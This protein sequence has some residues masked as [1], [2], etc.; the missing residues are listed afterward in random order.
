[1]IRVL[2]VLGNLNRGGAETMIMNL[3][4]NIDR[5]KVQFDFIIHTKE[6]CDYT[7]EVKALGGKIFS[8]PKYTGKN[9]RQYKKHWH[10]FFKM[11]QEYKI[12][13]GHVRS[14]ASIYLNIA[15]RYG[16][17]TIVHSHSTSSGKGLSALVKNL[18]QYRIRNIS[19]YLFACSESAGIWLFG[20]KS[21]KRD[22]FYI[23]KNAVD[24]KKYIYNERIRLEKRKE[25]LLDGRFVVGH[26]GRFHE[27]KNHN[28]LVDI[29]KS[30]YDQNKKAVLM[31]VGDGQLRQS[32]EKKV[33][34]LGLG[35]SVIFTGVRSNIPELLQV[36]DV[37]VFPSIYEGLPVTLIEAQA[38]GLK[39][40][41]SDNITSEVN[42]T[43]LVKN[44]SLKDT[45][46]N[47]A[48]Q[49]LS[50]NNAYSRKDTSQEIIKSGYDIKDSSKWLE[51]FY[52][53]ISDIRVKK[54]S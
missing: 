15:K 23:L 21:C 29:F 49:I 19:E 37:F 44:I 12:I 18:L 50:A 5:S 11:H 33:F 16:L 30:I 28:F 41:V 54:V 35:D 17:T 27:S 38:S 10:E 9:H 42:V 45:E 43:D 51:N 8:I 40:F 25:F 39:C 53:K 22:N 1:M 36:M 20:K 26:I 24:A 13:H 32:I 3:Y 14:T 2:H 52:L 47:W 6:K 48:S 4:R 7:E 34:E 46:E 31:L